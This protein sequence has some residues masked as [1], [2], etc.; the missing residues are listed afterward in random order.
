MAVDDRDPVTGALIFSDTGAPDIG[1]DPTL[2][3]AQANDVGTRI[4][5][6]NLA[7][8]EAYEYKRVGLR[9]YAQDTG[10]EYVHS[11]TGWVQQGASAWVNVTV[12]SGWTATAGYTPQVRLD[13]SRVEI[14]GAVTITSGSFASMVTVPVQFRPS[15][16]RWVGQ[17]HGSTSGAT[18]MLLIDVNGVIQIPTSYRSGAG[19]SGIVFPLAGFWHND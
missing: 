2:V 10:I 1:V 7:A 8:L 12:G 17:T 14:R 15:A 18:G 3:S 16:S 13:G 5:R 11:G 19:T 4:I 9:G 6:T